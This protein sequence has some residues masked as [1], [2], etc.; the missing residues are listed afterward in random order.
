MTLQEIITY[1]RGLA[2]DDVAPYLWSDSLLSTFANEAQIE[3]AIRSRLLR[4]STS[5]VTQYDVDAGDTSIT[6]D[7]RVV[8]VLG[9]RL[10]SKT[11]PLAKIHAKDL[12]RLAPGWR[13]EAVGD[14]IAYC[15]DEETG[16][17]YFHRPFAAADTVQLTVIRE[18]LVAMALSVDTVNGTSTT[19]VSDAVDPEIRVRHQIK[20][21]DWMLHRA[22]NM[23]DIEEKYDPE[24]AMFHLKEFEAAFGKRTSAQDE[25]WIERENRYDDADGVY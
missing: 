20:L 6:L 16:V 23:R 25:E 15:S 12:D 8:F 7:P 4:D 14:T 18:P 10:L 3:A 17:L 11:Q 2:Q 22:L 9:V 24:A 5:A 19:H 1:F 13:S 21:V